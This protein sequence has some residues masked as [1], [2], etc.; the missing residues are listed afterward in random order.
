K[1]GK[2]PRS[3]ERGRVRARQ[4]VDQ[5][6]RRTLLIS[7]VNDHD[8][9]EARPFFSIHVFTNA[10]QSDESKVIHS[11]PC[12]SIA[13]RTW[14]NRMVVNAQRATQWLCTTRRD[15]PLRA[16]GVEQ[17]SRRGRHG[18]ACCAPPTASTIGRSGSGQPGCSTR[19]S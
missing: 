5:P 15:R 16:E 14:S 6:E 17:R 19:P 8:N 1:L 18:I 12:S 2:H 11:G 7:I 9:F 4:E 3:G 10:K 13:P